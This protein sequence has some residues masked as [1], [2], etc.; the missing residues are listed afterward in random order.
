[1][2]WYEK[3]DVTLVPLVAV[4]TLQLSGDHEP[5]LGDEI[6]EDDETELM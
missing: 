6:P 1:M 3:P 2:K 4:R 5:G